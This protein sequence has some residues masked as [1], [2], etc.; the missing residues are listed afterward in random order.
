MIQIGLS[1]AHSWIESA[2]VGVTMDKRMITAITVIGTLFAVGMPIILAIYLSDR[3]A[4]DAETMIALTY[5]RDVSNRTDGI[6]DQTKSAVEK[7]VRAHS[8]DPCSDENIA[9]MRQI[10]LTSSFLQ[11]VGS[12]S[13]DRLICSSIGSFGK[14]LDLGSVDFVTPYPAS[15]RTTVEFPFAKGTQFIVIESRGY[16][17]I[18]HKDLLIDTTTSEKDVS[19]AA[20][21]T[22]DGRVVSSRGFIKT[23]WTRMHR[24]LQEATFFDGNYIVAV[25]RSRKQFT[26]AVVA[27]P[28]ARIVEKTRAFA[29]VM[30]P[31]GAVA[32]VVLAFLVL[33]LGRTQLA[34]PAVIKAA[35]RRNEFHVVYQPIVELSTG[36][37]AGAEA[38]IRWIR[39][40][41]ET[42]R[43]DLFIPIAEQSDLILRITERVLELV[44]RDAVGLFQRHPDFY[45]TVNLSPAD[46]HSMRTVELL[47]QLIR[48]LKAI[49]NNLMVEATERGLVNTGEGLDVIQKIRTSG[50]RVG[51]DDFGTG[52]SSLSY[53]ESFDLDFLKIDR[54]FVKSVGTGAA[55]NHVAHHI[56]EMGKALN[57]KIIAEGVETEAQARFL[58][59]HGVDYVQG[60]LYAKPMTFSDLTAKL[61]TFG[62]R[63]IYAT[64]KKGQARREKNVI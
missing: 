32:G 51:I 55:T 12:V 53:L 6:G 62:A 22:A 18:I 8:K 37:W 15:F 48:N 40:S 49:P 30:A 31:V 24:D 35:L 39:P 29:I 56:I 64:Q 25:V 5:A 52:Y 34:M 1:A 9:L 20:F 47:Q 60:F 63:T 28:V 36:K 57:L 43:P 14:G 11:A 45:F 44:A 54:A 7:L 2:K 46:L 17:A 13:H 58:D 27:I 3:Q 59:E 26:G 41:G 50:I 23:E 61:E 19:V 33:L 21:T 16:A 4:R 38:L 42:V 10:D